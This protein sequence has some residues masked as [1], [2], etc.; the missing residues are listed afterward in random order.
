V[1]YE[2]ISVPAVAVLLLAVL[3]AVDRAYILPLSYGI[4][5]LIWFVSAF[6]KIPL[7]AYYSANRYGENKA[8]SNPL[9]MKTN[10]LLTAAWGFLYLLT[11]IWTWFLMGTRLSAFTGLINSIVPAL[12]GIITTWFQKWYPARYARG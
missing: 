5:G 10:R 11:P 8:F 9:F 6:M 2:Q 4:F 3:F 7:T 12:M 1:P